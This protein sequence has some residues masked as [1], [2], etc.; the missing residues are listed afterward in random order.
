MTECREK[1]VSQRFGLAAV[2]ALA[3]CAG[4]ARSEQ[5]PV[6]HYTTADGL[7]SSKVT[8]IFQDS[9]GF[10]WFSTR[11]GLSRF[12]GYRFVTYDTRHGLSA[13]TINYLIETRAGVYWVAT[14]GGGVCRFNPEAGRAPAVASRQSAP[15]FTPYSVGDTSVTN[16]V[17]V[18]YEDRGNRLWAGTDD[19]LFLLEKSS[20][21]REEFR[22]VALGGAETRRGDTEVWGVAEDAEGTLWVGT[23]GGVARLLSGGRVLHYPVAPA[24][25]GDPVRDLMADREGRIWVAHRRGLFMHAPRPAEAEAAASTNSR[26]TAFAA[27]GARR[28]TTADGLAGDSVRYLHQSADGRLWV[29]T[30]NGLSVFDG[31]DFRNYTTA[32]GLS[33][34]FIGRMFEDRDGNLWVSAYS[35]GVMRL[36]LTG[37][38]SYT[39]S[40]GLG[41]RLIHSIYEDETGALAVVSDGW[42]VNRFEGGRFTAARLQVPPDA[43]VY[44]T[45]QAGFLDREGEWWMSS[46]RGLVRFGKA[47]R[48]QELAQQ[49]PRAVYTSRD[50]LLDDTVFMLFEDS[51]GDLWVSTVGGND[52]GLVRWERST[53][54]FRA[55]GANEGLPPRAPT[56]SPSAFAE[57]KD[58]RLWIG[59][60]DGGLV[61]YAGGRFRQFTAADGVPAG[62]IT[63]LHRDR[64]GRLWIATNQGGLARVDDTS[65]ERP[66]FTTYTTEEGLSSNNVRCVTEDL[67]GRIYAGTARGVDR[68]DPATGRLRHYTL[69]EGLANDFL[70]TAFRDRE[71]ALWFG[72]LNGLSRLVPRPE[73]PLRPTPVLIGALRVAGLPLPLSELGVAGVP[74]LE[75][76]PDQ[77]Q[78]QVDFFG[79]SHRP[80]EDLLYQY[81]LEGADRDW[82]APTAQRTINYATLQ[83][84]SYTFKVRSINAD[85]V[86]SPEPATFSFNILPP[87][88]RRWWF[89]ALA[90]LAMTAVV[91]MTYRYRV[92]RLLEI[93]R[94]RTRIAT[95]LH[96]DIGASLSQIAIL[97]E[98]ASQRVGRDGDGASVT[99]PL[100]M[101]ANTS[102]EM[103]DTMSDIVWAINPRRD[104]LSDL[105]HRMR[106]FASDVLA[107]RDIKFRFSAPPDEKVLKLGTDLRREVYLIFKES[108]NNVA[109]HSAC[110]EADLE[111]VVAGDWLVVKVS[112][113][114]KGF[115]AA[116]AG[117]GHHDGMGGH[118]LHSMRQRAAALGG[119][120]E[121]ES[122][123]GRGTTVTLKVPVAGRGLKSRAREKSLPK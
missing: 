67:Q 3:I 111:I 41:R 1:K 90:A 72:T 34:N 86:V 14:N 18:L 84:G 25:D 123:K 63:S 75:L 117:N 29:G 23:L 58:G 44:W 93:E 65:R 99:E 83:P 61:Q 119:S 113:N 118:G 89:L 92:R 57:D 56:N 73:P 35:G 9:R 100:E 45:G 104:R 103:V 8:H 95:D 81:M 94:V 26:M 106:R 38:V 102:R 30:Q 97:S 6:K 46:D 59:Y 5:L 88:W 98:V 33:D 105:T 27:G 21:G 12:D 31:R 22:R 66:S 24:A 40:D 32:Q 62:A 11:D 51:R 10:I 20:D 122:G 43:T 115:D 82:G 42:F 101:I 114:G 69:G 71:G 50:G 112:D 16:R 60:N 48:L 15:L 47:G 37:M 96:D 79:I 74:S 121:V 120:Y 68:L 78:V 77:N 19:G 52:R 91:Y 109:K 55:F 54:T 110:T 85:G 64:S 4:G 36:A 49:K 107:A 28:F 76:G 7:G 108:V 70:T 17:N 2:L 80:G 13:P 53:E 116:A 87:V 39:E